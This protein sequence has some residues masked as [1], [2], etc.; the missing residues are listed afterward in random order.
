MANYS[1]KLANIFRVERLF[2]DFIVTFLAVSETKILNEWEIFEKVF[3]LEEF[4][5]NV[6][7]RMHPL[8]RSKIIY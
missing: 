8:V 5:V 3:S 1:Y 2:V 6:C 7:F 4:V